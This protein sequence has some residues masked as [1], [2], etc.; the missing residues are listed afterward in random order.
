MASSD[1]D[2]FGWES[3]EPEEGAREREDPRTRGGWVPPEARAWRH[4][5]E[6]GSWA[7]SH[8]GLRPALRTATGGRRAL[9]TTALAGAGAV[10]A[11]VGG[12]LMLANRDRGPELAAPTQLISPPTSSTRSIVR[13]TVE[14][15]TGASH[16][17]CG[18]VVAGE[19]IATNASLLTGATGIVATTSTGR[20]TIGRVVAVDPTSDV[21]LIRVGARLPVGRFVDWSDVQPGTG[22]V[23]LAVATTTGGGGWS[24]WLSGTIASIGEPVSSGPGS[25]MVSVVATTPK[26]TAPDGAVLMERDGAIVGLLDKSGV[27]PQGGGAVFLPGEFV[28]EVAHE[29]LSNG[30]QIAHGW[31]GIEGSDSAS[32]A[33]GAVVTAVSSGG[34]SSGHLEVGDLI[35]SIDG[36]RVRTMADL[37]SRLYL[38]SPGTAVTL[39][40]RRDGATR[41]VA[42]DLGTSP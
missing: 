28:F 19:L 36:H 18:V 10:V 6:T 32:G 11:L 30:G 33:R 14:Q 29:L 17:G 37:R 24:S 7:G 2:S 31:L 34:P 16:Y 8:P 15:R 42:V 12:G 39:I 9:W 20:R 35:T 40:V 26:G 41:A 13:L 5:S 3:G 27:S 23:E 1:G 38:L 21:G 4:P 22:A 25:G